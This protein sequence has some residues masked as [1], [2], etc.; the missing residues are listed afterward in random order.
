MLIFWPLLL[1]DSGVNQFPPLAGRE[2]GGRGGVQAA[3]HVTSVRRDTMNSRQW[4]V[5]TVYSPH[6]ADRCYG[7]RHHG[8]ASLHLRAGVK[9][10][11]NNRISGDR[12]SELLVWRDSGLGSGLLISSIKYSSTLNQPYLA[13]SVLRVKIVRSSVCEMWNFPV[14]V[15]RHLPLTR[16]PPLNQNYSQTVNFNFTC[17]TLPWH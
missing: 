10:Y 16:P 11:N 17:S 1:G 15:A 14:D 7:P 13:L 6:T 3:R 8:K 12:Y 9:P 5:W 4:T 2:G